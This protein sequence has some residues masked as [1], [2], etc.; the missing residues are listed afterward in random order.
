LEGSARKVRNSAKK[1]ESC[2]PETLPAQEETIR[3]TVDMKASLH[4]KLS[5][6]AARQGKKKVDIV[7]DA[8][9]QTLKSVEE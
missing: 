8:L 6:L 9:E 2:L 7:R 1:E 4:R 5:L 3:F